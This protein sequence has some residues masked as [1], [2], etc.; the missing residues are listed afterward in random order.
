MKIKIN[1]HGNPLPVAKGEWVDLY[2]AEEAKLKAGEY[3]TISLGVSMELPKGYYAVVVPRSSA[4]KTWGVMMTN[5]MGIIENDY[6][7]DGD[8]WGFPALAMHDTVI[9]K[10][11]RLCQFQ[12]VKRHRTIHFR[13]VTKLG[14]KN[15]GGFGS[16]GN[17]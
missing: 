9:P 4:F 7:G 15:R 10:G 13:Q 12:I 3:R 5:S 1:T 11:T 6:C 14:N 17:N 16:T 2:T 8:V